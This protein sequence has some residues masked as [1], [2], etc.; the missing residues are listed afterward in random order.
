MKSLIILFFFFVTFAH[1]I[2]PFRWGHYKPHLIYSLSEEDLQPITVRMAFGYKYKSIPIRYDLNGG[3][4]TNLV[5]DYNYNNGRDFSEQTIYDK[6]SNFQFKA[7]TIKEQ[8]SWSI[9]L[10]NPDN[11]GF[12]NKMLTDLLKK[13]SMSKSSDGLFN[14]EGFMENDHGLFSKNSNVNNEE[15]VF[16]FSIGLEQLK[17]HLDIDIK[18]YYIMKAEDVENSFLIRNK[19][20]HE[21]ISV[22]KLKVLEAGETKPTQF[23]YKFIKRGNKYENWHLGEDLKTYLHQDSSSELEE[24]SID[25][26]AVLLKIPVKLSKDFIIQLLYQEDLTFSLADHYDILPERL[27]TRRFNF[28]EDFIHKFPVTTSPQYM[29]CSMSSLSN[30]IGGLSYMYG[31]IKTSKN[32]SAYTYSK[33]LFT[34]T[35]CRNGFARGFLWDEGFHNMILAQ[36]DQELSL[37]SITHWL[38]TVIEETGWL[39]REQIR[40]PEVEQYANRDFLVQNEMEA[41]PPT[42]I[43]PLSYLF[44]QFKKKGNI[45]GLEEIKKVWR[46]AKLWFDW[47]HTS[48]RDTQSEEYIYHWVVE[49]NGFNLGSGMDDYPR[50]DPRC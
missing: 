50:N 10:K 27:Q 28:L 17:Q 23:S 34:M 12:V 46:K 16:G 47:F 7:I 44:Q 48:Q 30:L 14:E 19:S 6:S 31:P 39:P 38:E 49:R 32:P 25:T 45:E 43:I 22:L 24:N 36:Y 8:N 40:G 37:K 1:S 5:L 26:T 9:Y 11:K 29:Q 15:V 41:N 18:N 33:P 20:N 3:D 35:P 2:N 4:E 42:L 13:L 21:I